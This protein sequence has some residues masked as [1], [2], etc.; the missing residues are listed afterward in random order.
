MVQADSDP[1]RVDDLLRAG[2]DAAKAGD[3]ERARDLLMQVVEL[4]Q[5]RIPAWLWLSG[6]VDGDDREVCLENVL[7]LD[8]GNDAARRGLD[9]VQ[10]QKRPQ[11]QAAVI[12]SERTT[13]TPSPPQ[14][15]TPARQPLW[16]EPPDPLLCPY[17]VASTEQGDRR[18]PACRGELV[19]KVRRRE[20]HS[21]W[22]WNL[23]VVRFSMALFYAL[24]PLIA[25]TVVAYMLWHEFDPLAL[26]PVYLGL[27]H[28]VAPGLAREALRML[29]RV[30]LLPFFALALFSI[31]LLVG[32]Y[33]RW[34]PVFYVLL[35]SLAVRFALAVTAVALGQYYGLVCG[36]FGVIVALVSFF[37]IISV[38]DDF[39]QD[40]ERVYFALDRRF[41]GGV[42]RLEQARIASERGMW[43]LAA[44][45][46]RAAVAKM[47]G[48]ASGYARLA[49]AYLRLGRS[50]L[51]REALQQAKQ[52]DPNDP[53]VIEL[54]ALL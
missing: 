39:A 30:Y 4:D 48:Q 40:T 41:Q 8:P 50:D 25:L 34:K 13:A 37:L 2:I 29:P 10:A 47:P 24:M 51:A 28:N 42:A 54:F 45:N 7:T 6:V 12:P 38:G 23:M 20:E 33:V 11:R 17:C 36:S 49:H 31:A 35:G 19:Y 21:L 3:R 15:A 22:L 5:E 43:A 53:R 18:C 32:M 14:C 46:L 26:L 44:L 27:R 52:I 16:P 9:W 1:E